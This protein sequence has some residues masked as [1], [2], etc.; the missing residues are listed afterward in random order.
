MKKPKVSNEFVSMFFIGIIA[1]FLLLG[2]NMFTF[3]HQE[4]VKRN[5]FAISACDEAYNMNSEAWAAINAVKSNTNDKELINKCDTALE[6]IGQSKDIIM[7]IKM[8]LS[9]R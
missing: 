9:H 6:R 1:L 3:N 5:T 2:A 8:T 7:K 4:D